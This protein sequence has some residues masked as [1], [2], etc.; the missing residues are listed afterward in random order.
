MSDQFDPPIGNEDEAKPEESAVARFA[1]YVAGTILSPSDT[2]R[3]IG[4]REAIIPALVVVLLMTAI[5]SAGQLALL[6]FD[7]GPFATLGTEIPG[8]V[9][10]SL[11][12]MQVSSILW[13]FIMAPV[14]WVITA[15]LLFG[16]AWL[17]GGRGRFSALWAA[18]GFAL[19]PQLI[20]APVSV[21][22][23]LLGL[24]DAGFQFLG[25]LV[26][27]PITIGA[28]I[29][30][31]VLFAISVRETMNLTTGRSA[32]AVGLLIGGVILLAIVIACVVIIIIA[33]IVA[34]LAA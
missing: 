6:A 15:G 21:A 20:I 30:V 34:A 4:E 25:L 19:V 9:S 1:E 26:T 31:L 2:L 22:G 24:L 33:G 11:I 8:L 16:A 23:E 17:L 27:L 32:G 10:G 13:N 14:L 29:W 12:A 18:T 3:R 28:F 7:L 5:N